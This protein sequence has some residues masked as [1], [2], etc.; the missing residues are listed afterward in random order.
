V[1]FID[2]VRRV[3][4]FRALPLIG[5]GLAGLA[6][7][8]VASAPA[9]AVVLDTDHPRATATHHDFGVGWVLGAPVDGGDLEWDLVNGVTRPRLSGYHYL[10][11]REC[12]KVFVEYFNS[13]GVFL[14]SRSS[15]VHC[16]PDNGKTQWWVEI[17]SFTST[18]V[19]QARVA[20]ER[21][22]SN[23]TFTRMASDLEVF[24]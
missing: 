23:G 8:L 12:G 11:D 7:V 19:T 6:L 10:T 9:S 21:Q 20:V 13:A 1:R 14:G 24:N 22:N 16:A 18:S 3:S 17:D 5:A 15:S 2:I 4:P